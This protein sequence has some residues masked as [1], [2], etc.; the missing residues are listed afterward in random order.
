METLDVNL[1]K[2]ILPGSSLFGEILTS[3]KE[4]GTYTN[5]IK[6]I[7]LVSDLFEHHQSL[8]ASTLSVIFEEIFGAH[9][10]WQYGSLF[11]KVELSIALLNL[12]GA[13]LSPKT[14][15]ESVF[16]FFTKV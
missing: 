15:K 6:I 12:V 7:R 14:S 16:L 3:E 11:E 10:N 9:L 13:V 1:V 2:K 5:T 4:L 8:L